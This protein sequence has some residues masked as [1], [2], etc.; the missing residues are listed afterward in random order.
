MI[1]VRCHVTKEV[2]RS[3]PYFPVKLDKRISACSHRI[4]A[5]NH[6]Q[7]T[8][9]YVSVLGNIVRPRGSLSNYTGTARFPGIDWGKIARNDS[10]PSRFSL[11]NLVNEMGIRQNKNA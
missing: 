1:L 11:L 7:F 3:T 5:R 9:A 6:R 8:L 2:S 10:L 4:R